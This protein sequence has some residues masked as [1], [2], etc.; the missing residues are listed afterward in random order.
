[1]DKGAIVAVNGGKRAFLHFCVSL[2]RCH[3]YKWIHS[4]NNNRWHR[5]PLVC[6]NTRRMQRTLRWMRL[7]M[8]QK[9]QSCASATE[10]TF[11][12]F[13]DSL[14]LAKADENAKK[15]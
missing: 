2:N 1:M 9:S 12:F 4:S 8:P 13:I 10:A 5:A 3:V 14:L 15:R 7:T 11:L 6:R